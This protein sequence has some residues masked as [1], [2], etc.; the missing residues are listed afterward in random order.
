MENVDLS[1]L[2]KE[3]LELDRDV[4][5][6]IGPTRTSHYLPD[7][8]GPSTESCVDVGLIFSAAARVA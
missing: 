7:R 2:Q 5:T 6:S 1:E 4:A 8:F 3:R